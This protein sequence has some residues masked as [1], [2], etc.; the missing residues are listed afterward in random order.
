MLTQQYL[1]FLVNL[2]GDYGFTVLQWPSL[3]KWYFIQ[4]SNNPW[5]YFI[6]SCWQE[7][8]RFWPM[9]DSSIIHDNTC[10]LIHEK[11]HLKSYH[12]DIKYH[13]TLNITFSVVF[14]LCADYWP[15]CV[16]GFNPCQAS[17]N[18][19]RLLN[20]VLQVTQFLLMIFINIFVWLPMSQRWFFN[21]KN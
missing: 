2:L 8:V 1:S 10:S 14:T 4:N 13:M 5:Q 7:K 6:T 11:C 18:Q 21:I 20:P 3:T 9:D 17:S 16:C 12:S 15:Y 19:T